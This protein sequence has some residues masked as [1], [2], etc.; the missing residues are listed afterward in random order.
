MRLLSQLER[1]TFLKKMK[2]E[3]KIKSNILLENFS[4]LVSEKINYI[5]F[6][7]PKSALKVTCTL[8]IIYSFSQQ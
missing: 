3:A 6:K 4:N 1:K 7:R 8:K 2:P 5:K